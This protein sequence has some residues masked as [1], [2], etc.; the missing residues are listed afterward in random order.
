[1]KTNTPIAQYKKYFWFHVQR[2][3]QSSDNYVTFE[4]L[5]MSNNLKNFRKEQCEEY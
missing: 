3:L 5:I 1:M 2:K 4:N